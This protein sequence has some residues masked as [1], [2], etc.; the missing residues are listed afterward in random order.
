VL[1]IFARDI[2]PDGVGEDEAVGFAEWEK[3]D[4]AGVLFSLCSHE[5]IGRYMGEEGSTYEAIL[6]AGLSLCWIVGAIE[7]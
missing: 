5:N 2:F 7:Y 3:E 4:V 1:V 6:E